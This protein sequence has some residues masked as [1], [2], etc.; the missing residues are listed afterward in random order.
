MKTRLLLSLLAVVVTTGLAAG[1][2]IAW[3]VP[4]T[5]KGYDVALVTLDEPHPVAQPNGQVL[6]YRQAYLVRLFGDFAAGHGPAPAIY[7]GD[8]RIPEFGSFASGLYFLIYEKTKLDGL[9]G[10]EI[11]Y[12]WY[13]DASIH[14]LGRRFE[15]DRYDLTTPV[16]L[17]QALT[18]PLVQPR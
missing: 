1:N 12:T 8:E 15:P 5:F 4:L 11:R 9:A 14:N 6:T 10:R 3:P 2:P 13:N 18:R 17:Q 7:L 16:P